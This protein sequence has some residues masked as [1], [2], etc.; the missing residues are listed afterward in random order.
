MKHSFIK[1]ALE[2]Y[3]L[4]CVGSSD[5]YNY[6]GL[7]KEWDLVSVG[8]HEASVH[9]KE[10]KYKTITDKFMQM[11]Q[12][13]CNF[14]SNWFSNLAWTII[15]VEND[16][17]EVS[18][19]CISTFMQALTYTYLACS[20][21]FLSYHCAYV[22]PVAFATQ[23]ND[24]IHKDIARWANDLW[25]KSIID[26]LKVFNTVR[27]LVF[28]LRFVKSVKITQNNWGGAALLT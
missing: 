27:K 28:T 16:I 18:I 13:E 7:N 23:F 10:S 6:W 22:Y 19:Q 25:F 21:F 4:I 20:A 12:V 17:N 24:N 26:Y 8:E 5:Q 15:F 1:S 2:T 11:L 3:A 14:H 9:D